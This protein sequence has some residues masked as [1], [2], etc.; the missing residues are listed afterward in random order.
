MLLRLR[1]DTSLI[2][3]LVLR[4]LHDDKSIL[5]SLGA[6]QP[7]MTGKLYQPPIMQM[8][9]VALQR[10]KGK[11][12]VVSS[13]RVDVDPA[14][15]ARQIQVWDRFK[16]AMKEDL[17]RTTRCLLAP[18]LLESLT[19]AFGS[20]WRWSAV[21]RWLCIRQAIGSRPRDYRYIRRYWGRKMRFW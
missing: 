18:K 15:D 19:L 10:C 6:A 21:R 9:V 16:E 11:T 13:A 4:D 8:M 7:G 17:V 3:S 5:Q 12:G 14:A 2:L 20:L 1:L